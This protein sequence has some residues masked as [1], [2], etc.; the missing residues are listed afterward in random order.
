M[1]ETI[2]IHPLYV[3][4][5]FRGKILAL[6]SLLSVL[7]ITSSTYCK[8]VSCNSQPNKQRKL[9]Y[10]SIISVSDDVYYYTYV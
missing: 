10:K 4:M 1:R 3:F 8:N 9:A 7:Q 2:F 6:R 5:A